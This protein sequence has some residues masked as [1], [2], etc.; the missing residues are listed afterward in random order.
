MFSSS[1]VV[2][3]TTL[4]GCEI[5][6][7]SG[8]LRV[9]L[10]LHKAVGEVEH[11]LMHRSQKPNMLTAKSCNPVHMSN[12]QLELTYSWHR[13]HDCQKGFEK[14]G[15]S[16]DIIVDVSTAVKRRRT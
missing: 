7:I 6:H 14:K 3:I 10:E 8:L 11:L 16:V 2:T 5:S 1:K 9:N 4:A 15:F 12:R 13:I